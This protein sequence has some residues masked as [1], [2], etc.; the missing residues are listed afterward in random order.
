[1]TVRIISCHNLAVLIKK[2]KAIDRSR[3]RPVPICPSRRRNQQCEEDMYE[4]IRS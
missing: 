2:S 4:A 1:M 3:G